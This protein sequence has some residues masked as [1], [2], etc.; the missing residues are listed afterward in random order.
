M[1][2]WASITCKKKCICL[3]FPRATAQNSYGIN[4][5]GAIQLHA[6]YISCEHLAYVSNQMHITCPNTIS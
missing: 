4:K 1:S 5:R 3:G 6:M 2:G